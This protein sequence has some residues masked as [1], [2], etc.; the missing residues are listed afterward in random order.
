MS[1]AEIIETFRQDE[2][3]SEYKLTLSHKDRKSVHE[4]CEKFGLYSASSGPQN[5]RILT[6]SKVPLVQKLEITDEERQIFIKNTGLPIPVWR[7]P[8]FAYFINLYKDVYDSEN[9]YQLFTYTI[10]TLNS[11]KRQIIPYSYELMNQICTSIKQQPSY[12]NL[13]DDGTF[14]CNELPVSTNIYVRNCDTYPQYYISLDIIKANFT[15][16]KFYDKQ[17]ILNC[18]NWE[19]FVGKFTDLKYFATAKYFR[20]ACLGQLKIGKM[21]AIQLYLLSYLYVLIKNDC[22]IMGRTGND[23][24]IISVTNDNMAEIHTK[25]NEI[26]KHL[27]LKMQ[28]V[29]RLESFSLEPIGTSHTFVKKIYDTGNTTKVVK[30]QIKNIEKDFHAQAYKHVNGQTLHSYDFKAMKDNYLITY[31]DKY[32]FSAT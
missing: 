16:L 11:Q 6:I 21:A 10:E 23:E 32:T 24:I 26:L 19:E 15:A 17:L 31:E 18:D 7:E 8:Y 22:Q 12:K 3:K 4:M 25:I 13:L 1:L 9:M 2:T 20:Q 5:N 28:N 29:W 30:T 27:P 14:V